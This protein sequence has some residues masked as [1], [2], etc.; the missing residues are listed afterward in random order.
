[1]VFA[2]GGGRS[3]EIGSY[4]LMDRVS[5]GQDKKVLKMDMMFAQQCEYT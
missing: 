1:M 4:C 2:T 5:V 3:G